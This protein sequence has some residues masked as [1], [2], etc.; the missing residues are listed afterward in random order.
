MPLAPAASVA[1]YLGVA[2]DTTLSYKALNWGIEQSLSLASAA[3]PASFTC[4]LS[5]PG[6]TLA[7]DSGGQWGLYAPG[8]P[9]PIFLL[10]GHRSTTRPLSQPATPRA[11]FERDHDGR[12]RQRSL[13]H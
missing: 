13:E 6:L 12:P 3:A 11:A 7:Q 9:W 5:H 10:V 1:S 2:T 4:T 8:N